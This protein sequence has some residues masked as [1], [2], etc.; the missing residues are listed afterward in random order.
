MTP[1]KMPK[2]YFLDCHSLNRS[3]MAAVEVF[4]QVLAVQRYTLSSRLLHFLFLQPLNRP[5]N[6]THKFPKVTEWPQTLQEIIILKK[7]R[8]G[9]LN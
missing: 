3:V 8:R 7:H 2:V 1:A 9:K 4:L 5:T 6:Q